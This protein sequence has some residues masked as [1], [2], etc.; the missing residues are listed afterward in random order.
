MSK[1]LVRI[2]PKNVF[3]KLEKADGLEINA[4]MQNGRTYF[5]KIASVSIDGLN[6]KDTR[7]HFHQLA[8]SDLYEIVY[9][10]E[11]H[12]ILLRSE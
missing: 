7:N 2:Y 8:L 9:D 12:D 1:R 4:V 10:E 11:N 6:I 5:G 3:S